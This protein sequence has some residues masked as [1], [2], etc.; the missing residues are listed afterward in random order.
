M[1]WLKV[2]FKRKCAADKISF[3]N[4]LT[5]FNHRQRFVSGNANAQYI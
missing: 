4:M 1:V 2:K 5:N 3:A